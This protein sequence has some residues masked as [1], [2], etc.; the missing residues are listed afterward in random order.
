LLSTPFAIYSSLATLP[1]DATLSEAPKALLNEPET[2]TEVNTFGSVLE[3]S[4]LLK[5]LKF[6]CVCVCVC[7]W[8]HRCSFL[9]HF[10]VSFALCIPLRITA[11]F[12]LIIR[13]VHFRDVL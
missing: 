4:C 2:K 13:A 5:Q 12:D 9:L 10:V 6:V 1:Y 3:T 11:K 7:V 8:C